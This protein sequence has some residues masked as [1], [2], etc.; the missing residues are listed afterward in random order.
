MIYLYNN[1]NVRMTSKQKQK[2][3]FYILRFAFWIKQFANE[4]FLTV[5]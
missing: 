1:Y 3:L 4:L 2:Q 5:I